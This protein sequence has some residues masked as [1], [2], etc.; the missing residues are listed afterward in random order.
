VVGAWAEAR[1]RLRA[2][3]VR[4]TAGMTV[5][6]L[7]SAATPVGGHAVAAELH[8]LAASVDQALWSA[9]GPGERTATEAWAAVRAVRRGL[10]ARPLRV[11]LRAATD[12]RPLFR[13]R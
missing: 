4:S 8:V 1:D 12:P 2:H 9:S 13:P 10:A 7:A 5:R 3:G 6:D 11:R